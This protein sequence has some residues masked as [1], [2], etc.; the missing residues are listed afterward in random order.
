MDTEVL[1][2][3]EELV[4]NLSSLILILRLS[5]LLHVLMLGLFSARANARAVLGS[6]LNTVG[7][8]RVR[9]GERNK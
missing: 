4:R 9:R 3:P 1:F 7:S 6:K 5:C 8:G 2:S